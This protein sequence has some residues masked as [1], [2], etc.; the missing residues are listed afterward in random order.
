MCVTGN[1]KGG[2]PWRKHPADL[3]SKVYASYGLDEYGQPVATV[4]VATVIQSSTSIRTV[5]EY[6]H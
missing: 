6:S 4:N 3:L 2:S 1:E 5:S